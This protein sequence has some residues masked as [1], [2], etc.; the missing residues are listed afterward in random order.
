MTGSKGTS[1]WRANSL[2][3]SYPTPRGSRS[4]GSTIEVGVPG[5]NATRNEPV[6]AKTF[7]TSTSL[8]NAV[9]ANASSAA[10]RPTPKVLR[11]EIIS[12]LHPIGFLRGVASVWFDLAQPDPGYNQDLRHMR[13]VQLASGI[14]LV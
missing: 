13:N 12:S 8:A 3:N 14:S 4:L 10:K 11:F 1:S 5:Y 9:V 2:P 7:L 6:G